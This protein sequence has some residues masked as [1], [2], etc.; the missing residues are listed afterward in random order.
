METKAY[1]DVSEAYIRGSMLPNVNLSRSVIK[2]FK[3]GRLDFTILGKSQ[4][5]KTGAPY[6][7][8]NFKL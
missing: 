3:L 8:E 7:E 4:N 5:K 1:S 6:I 2:L